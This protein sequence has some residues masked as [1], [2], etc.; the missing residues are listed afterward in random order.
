MTQFYTVR[1]GVKEVGFQTA[2]L[3][4]WMVPTHGSGTATSAIPEIF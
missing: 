2:P 4:R 3:P 1:S